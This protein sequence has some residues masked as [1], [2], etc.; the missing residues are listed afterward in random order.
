MTKVENVT[1]KLQTVML[2]VAAFD[3]L[4]AAVYYSNCF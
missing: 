1:K 3:V 2:A 4:L